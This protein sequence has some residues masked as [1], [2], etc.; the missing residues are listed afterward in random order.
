MIL[1]LFFSNTTIKI[2]RMDVSRYITCQREVAR[3]LKLVTQETFKI[4]TVACLVAWPLNES[5]AEVD[6]VL[7]LL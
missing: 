6:L 2:S 5:E 7:T 4:F 1:L 3:P